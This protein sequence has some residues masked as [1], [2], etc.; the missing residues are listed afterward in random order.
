MPKGYWKTPGHNWTKQD[1]A[2]LAAHW[3]LHPD[4]WVAARIPSGPRTPD[5]CKIKAT[6]VLKQSRRANL[7]TAA[8]VARVFGIDPTTVYRVWGPKGWVA[9]SR[10]PMKQGSGKV[11]VVTPDSLRRLVTETPW[12]V[13]PTR[14]AA[15]HWL[16]HLAQEAHADPW[17]TL[18][19][20]AKLVHRTRGGVYQWVAKGWLPSQRRPH[21]GTRY[22]AH[23]GVH[24]V[25][26][27][28]LERI[29]ARL[30]AA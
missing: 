12:R 18:D 15:G 22:G 8:D 17:L 14:M 1:L 4:A 3:G 30:D 7:L 26:R 11:H 10:A 5:A 29:A 23:G 27:S 9:I 19:D 20:A 2:F 6:R 28:D 21:Y 24:V 16:T 13:D 25:R